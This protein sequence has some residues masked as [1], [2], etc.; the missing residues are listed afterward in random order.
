MDAV[1]QREKHYGIIGII[2][3]IIP[4]FFLSLSFFTKDEVPTLLSSYE[5]N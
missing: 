5:K 3:G 1:N 2:R 4:F